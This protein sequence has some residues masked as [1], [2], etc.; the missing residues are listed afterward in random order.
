MTA[1]SLQVPRL[2][3]HVKDR[4]NHHEYTRR[5]QIV[6]KGLASPSA[7]ND[8]SSRH[9]AK[10][11]SLYPVVLH[12]PTG[13]WLQVYLR[14]RGSCSIST[15]GTSLLCRTSTWQCMRTI[16]ASYPDPWILG[17]VKIAFKRSW[18]KW[19]TGIEHGQTVSIQKKSTASVFLISEGLKRRRGETIQLIV[20]ARAL[21]IRDQVSW[22][23]H[24]RSSAMET[25]SAL[26][27]WLRQMGVNGYLFDD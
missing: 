17:S 5:L 11:C 9:L 24:I 3:D 14:I 13:P 19:T 21:A 8:A 4:F 10:N 23:H 12:P 2:V 25:A 27:N 22:R 16:Y 18:T 20:Q 7:L 6:R 15:P 26:R 1:L